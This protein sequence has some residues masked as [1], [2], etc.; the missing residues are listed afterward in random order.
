MPIP[1]GAEVAR[2]QAGEDRQRGTAFAGRGHDLMD[3]LGVRTGEDLGELGNQHGRQGA[4]TD[5]RGQLPPEVRHRPALPLARRQV[6]D[7]QPAHAERR[8]DAQDRRDPDEAGQRLLEVEFLQALVLLFGDGL[9]DEVRHAGHEVHQEAHGEDPDDELGL[10]VDWT[11][12]TARV[13]KEI[14]ATPV[15]P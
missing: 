14:R 1:E 7:E 13:M 11:F 8:R 5:D 3:V 2:H 15:T 6:A 12:G 10:D 9:V 4:A